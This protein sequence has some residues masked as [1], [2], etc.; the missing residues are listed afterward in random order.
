MF[1]AKVALSKFFIPGRAQT[2]TKMERR[3]QGSQGFQALAAASVGLCQSGAYDSNRASSPIV[4]RCKSA[5]SGA[6]GIVR[7]AA[8]FQNFI[9]T[10]N[11]PIDT[12]ALRMP[13]S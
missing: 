9:N 13:T 10:T 1:G 8:G 2:K 11:E 6:I 3:I 7:S 4:V 5:T 12:K